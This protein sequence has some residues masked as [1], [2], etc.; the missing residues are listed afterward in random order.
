MYVVDLTHTHGKDLKE[1]QIFR[2]RNFGEAS[3]YST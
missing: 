2:A 3:S 1:S